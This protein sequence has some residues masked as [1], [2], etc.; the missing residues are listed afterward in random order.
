MSQQGEVEEV[1]LVERRRDTGPEDH[2]MACRSR[3]LVERNWHSCGME[4]SNENMRRKYRRYGQ[5]RRL[6]QVLSACYSTVLCMI[7]TTWS[8]GRT[9]SL[10]SPLGMVVVEVR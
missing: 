5:D 2:E 10:P 7:A 9:R 4:I 6:G 3:V 1:C 8:A